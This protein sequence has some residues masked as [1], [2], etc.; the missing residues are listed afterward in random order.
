MT[1]PMLCL[2]YLQVIA[3][4]QQ[5]SAVLPRFVQLY[6]GTVELRQLGLDVCTGVVALMY[7]FLAVLLEGTEVG[8]ATIYLHLY[9]RK[10]TL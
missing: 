7:E 1:I 9:G 3:L 2:S 4:G 6:P 10:V 5:L 8:V